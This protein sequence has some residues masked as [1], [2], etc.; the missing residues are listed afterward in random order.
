MKNKFKKS[1]F[2]L[3]SLM[4]LSVG[5]G[6]ISGVDSR[7]DTVEA[8][9]DIVFN[10]D[11]TGKK[12][13]LNSNTTAGSGTFTYKDSSNT[14]DI[15]ISY[16]KLYANVDTYT[17]FNKTGAYVSNST[18]LSNYYISSVS[19]SFSSGTSEK[20]V[21]YVNFSNSVVP[22]G[23]QNKVT[24]TKNGTFNVENTVTTNN[25]FSFYVS[26]ANNVQVTKMIIT[27]KSN[28]NDGNPFAS[29]KT[30]SSLGFSYDVD[31]TEGLDYV[32]QSS[33]LID[34]S[35]TYKIGATS[36]GNDFY[37]GTYGTN[38]F[39]YL[40]KDKKDEAAIFNI[41][42]TADST[43]TDKKYLISTSD[44]YLYYSG[45]SNHVYIGSEESIDETYYW[46][47]S[48]NEE[49]KNF[50]IVNYSDTERYLQY[51]A[52]SPRFACY[53]NTQINLDL[54]KYETSQVNEY[55]NFSNIRMRFA[56]TVSETQYNELGLATAVVGFEITGGGKEFDV[57]C[58]GKFEKD[59][60]NNYSI[61]CSIWNVPIDVELTAKAFIVIED[62]KNYAQE[63]SYSVKTLAQK[64]IDDEATLLA[65]YSEEAISAVKAF[66]AYVNA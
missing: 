34:Y 1:V 23:S 15:T 30:T 4:M 20:G 37:V 53:K 12:L 2:L 48:Y 35:G 24:V 29:I 11:F 22:N 27:F 55:S 51:N 13:G 17:M 41:S 9:D 33:S 62:V 64:Y 16:G 26:N 32:K 49:N 57:P 50:E 66:N 19:T 25:Y 18:T 42:L 40:T 65:G 54:Y 59:E 39:N 56:A 45:S 28:S 38:Y 3:S 7:V 58:T 46:T 47:I 52:S 21:P 8:A 43:E 60:Y 10:I 61:I 44:N 36:D 31:I 5:A 63:T 6:I 14:Y